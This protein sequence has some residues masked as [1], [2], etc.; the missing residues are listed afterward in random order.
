MANTVG[1]GEGRGTKD[2]FGALYG[3]LMLGKLTRML[4]SPKT[5]RAFRLR[6]AREATLFFFMRISLVG[7]MF[8]TSVMLTRK[9]GAAG[10]GV[11]VYATTVI[12]LLVVPAVFG[13]DQL[14]VREISAHLHAQEWGRMRG[15]LGWTNRTSTLI[16]LGLLLGTVAI[17]VVLSIFGRIDHEILWSLLVALIM[18]PLVALT[19]LRQGTLRGLFRIV[20]SQLPETVIQPV[21]FLLFVFVWLFLAKARLNAVLVTGM[22]VFS[23]AV[24][25]FVGS[26]LLVHYLPKPIKT[27]TSTYDLVAW[28]A[29]AWP[30]LMYS[31]TQFLNRRIDT[32]LLG[33]LDGPESVGV[34]TAVVRSVDLLAFVLVAINSVLAPT[35]VTLYK[36]GNI[37]RL[38]RMCTTSARIALLVTVIISIPLF[39]FGGLFL[40]IFGGDFAVGQSALNVLSITK[41]FN[42]ACGMQALT[43]TMTG[44]EKDVVFGVGAGAL[45]NT[46]LNL[47]L[48]PGL[49][50]MGAAIASTSGMVCWNIILTVRVVQRLGLDT[51]VLGLFGRQRLA[52]PL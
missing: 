39:M 1:N 22:H 50:I 19:R 44:F 29:S 7:L 51:T 27:A 8:I 30:L 5:Q 48:I 52:S 3:F 42:A 46:L 12:N 14:L 6:F 24:A 26:A 31:S 38:Q 40:T 16:S 10:F 13:L 9:M 41:I 47:L 34:Y 18:L 2:P 23:T 45:L 33:V 11:Y 43:L 28:R 17:V 25:F 4:R 36:S 20:P 37:K 49:G 32:L 15:L 21:L 35:I